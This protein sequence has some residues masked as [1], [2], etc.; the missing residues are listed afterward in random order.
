MP[1]KVNPTQCEA[2]T[3]VC[4]HIFG[5]HAALTFAGSQGH[6]ELNVFK[7]V[8]IFNVLQSIRLLADVALSFADNC[9]VGI[10]ANT[11]RID[12]HMQRSL[13]LVTALAP[14]I[15]Y[16]RA[17]TIAKVKREINDITAVATTAAAGPQ[18]NT[19]IVVGIGKT[20]I[21]CNAA[22][23]GVESLVDLGLLQLAA[24]IDVERFPFGKYVEDLRSRFAVAITRSLCAA[25]RQ[26][27]FGAD[28][29]QVYVPHAEL[30]FLAEERL[31][32]SVNH[33]FSALTGAST[34]TFA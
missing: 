26:V 20:G 8:I 24:V 12:E 33:L 21:N 17:A 19:E 9:V 23:E 3:M 11:A 13:M 4:A 22:L 34:V 5:N 6:F 7:P 28:A 1:G 16:E 10:E 31:P 14:K 30:A 32:A 25:K 27:N 29:R 18:E 15:G 2:L